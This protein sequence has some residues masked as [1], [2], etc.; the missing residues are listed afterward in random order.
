MAENNKAYVSAISLLDTREIL[1]QVVDI[2]NVIGLTDFMGVLGRY[3]PVTQTIFHN[4]VNKPLWTVGVSTGAVTGSGTATV[5]CSLTTGTSGSARLKDMVRFEDGS[6][7]YISAITPGSSDAIT[8]TSVDGTNLT[9][10]TGQN[11]YFFSNLAGESSAGRTNQRRD[12]TKYHQHIQIFEESN[13]ESD[14]NRMTLTEVKW[15]GVNKFIQKDLI[16]KWLKHKTEVNAAAWQSKISAGVFTTSTSAIL[17]PSS[18]GNMQSQ[19]GIDQYLSAYGST[20]S[21]DTLG[22]C[23]LDDIGKFIDLAIAKKAELKFLVV[24]ST[25]ARRP[26]D[27]YLKGIG[28]SGVSSAQLNVDGREID[29]EVEKVKYSNAIIQMARMPILDHPEVTASDIRKYLYFLNTGKVKAQSSKDGATIM[30]NRIQMRYM[31][32]PI[33]HNQINQGNDIWAEYHSGAASPVTP[34]GRTRN[35]ITDWV[36]YQAVEMLGAEHSGRMKTLS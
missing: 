32:N 1:D 10:T 2:Q 11:I 33:S 13:E 9:H 18:G 7:G 4:Y 27:D 36:T 3:K 30:E 6:V 17:D 21:T 35:W 25:A 15:D 20:R 29:F 28:S 34:S 26:L 5:S 22:T 12:L 19:R 16:E 8:V 23:D 24:G 31:K 14:L